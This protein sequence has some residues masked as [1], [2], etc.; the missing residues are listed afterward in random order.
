MRKLVRSVAFALG[1]LLATG[2]IAK[3][4]A[5]LSTGIEVLKAETRLVKCS[6]GGERV[7]FTEAEIREL[8]GL[9]FDYLTLST[10]PPLSCGVLKVA[11][12]DAVPGQKL[13]SAG[14][15]LL[16]F[17]PAK[18]FTES[19]S[20]GFT[21]AAT[22]WESDELECVIRFAQSP[23]F[24][25]IA[26]SAQLK[27]YKNVS[28]SAPLGAYDPDGDA[29]KYV[30]EEYPTGG[31]VS[32]A[33]GTVTY[34]PVN[35]FCGEDSFSYYAV[36]DWGKKSGTAKASITV[37][38]NESGI[39]FA[40]MKGSSEHLAAIRMS[41]EEV[42]T[43]C[44]IGD[45]YYFSPAEEVSRIDFAVMLVSAMGVEVTDK[46]YPTDVFTDTATQSRGKRLYLEAAVTNGV[47][48]VQGESFRPNDSISVADALAMAER[49]AGD[50]GALSIGTA[51]FDNGEELLTKKNAALL[52][53]GVYDCNGK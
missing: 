51:W 48:E 9:D 38:E 52:L 33:D 16:S 11:G 34:T 29:I 1:L 7:G 30:V 41:E 5:P 37:A 21:V 17:L 20:F 45:S 4:E 40:D 47:V 25:P 39:Y 19:C 46:L 10:L 15:A 28:V 26:V 23:D 2:L 43:Y 31:T 32:F 13:S 22:G 27:T 24:A 12:V 35:G 49:A 14:V 42:M 8:I 18:G 53:C 6:V 3:A 36:D 50:A 44:L